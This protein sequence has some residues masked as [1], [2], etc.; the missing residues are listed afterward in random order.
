[1]KLKEINTHNYLDPSNW[2]SDV[3]DNPAVPDNEKLPCRVDFVQFPVPK[4]S[5][6]V[7]KDIQGDHYVSKFLSGKNNYADKDIENRVI[8]KEKNLSGQLNRE[9]TKT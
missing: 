2:A 1:M 7:I 4:Y 6:M 8:G 9:I 5:S 3:A